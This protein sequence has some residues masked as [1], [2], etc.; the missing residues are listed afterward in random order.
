M[1]R[2]GVWWSERSVE[3]TQ[4]TLLDTMDIMGRHWWV[5]ATVVSGLCWLAAQA[6][7][8]A[9]LVLLS[10]GQAIEGI[11]VRQSDEQV[12]LQVAWE[13][14]VVLDRASLKKIE[15]ASEADRK[16]L[17]DRWK[18]EHQAYLDQE[19]RRRQFEAEQRARGL[20][21]YDGQ[22][23]SPEALGAIKARVAADEERRHL[24]E[25]LKQ[26]RLARQREEEERKA[27]EEEL[28]VLGERLRTMQE[29]QLR[30]QQEIS[31]LKCLL[32]RPRFVIGPIGITFVRDEHG[33]LLQVNQHA[34]HLFVETPDGIHTDLQ[35]HGDHL[36]YTDQRGIHHDVEQ[37]TR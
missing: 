8:W 12:V 15:P 7:A 5:K 14:Y 37:V 30:L 19:E 20:I 11:V 35:I 6:P 25:N 32:G 22:W 4:Q 33:N 17:L 9:D 29:E 16:T 27:R 3:L 21:L 28:K 1:L 36:S 23:M 31:S 13:G 2:K 34:G 10:N 26:E 18:Q 24:E